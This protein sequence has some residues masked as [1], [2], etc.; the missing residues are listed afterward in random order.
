MYTFPI[1]FSK[2]LGKGTS[3]GD[4]AKREEVSVTNVTKEER[5][6]CKKIETVRKPEKNNDQHGKQENAEMQATH[7]IPYDTS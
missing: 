7:I 1:I 5:T 4:G 6:K 2:F 3:E